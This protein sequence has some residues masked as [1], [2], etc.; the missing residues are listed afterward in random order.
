LKFP[1]PYR[2]THNIGKSAVIRASVHQSCAEM[3]APAARSPQKDDPDQQTSPGCDGA[4]VV[5]TAE[6][7]A[8]PVNF[9]LD[10][11]LAPQRRQRRFWSIHQSR[12]RK[13]PRHDGH[14]GEFA[15]QADHG[16][17]V[18]LALVPEWSV[19]DPQ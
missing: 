10:S 7:A 2:F 3:A 15:P 6:T 8:N 1:I 9:A 5:G 16:A 4:F 12:K 11:G 13:R 17:G 14:G 19:K 18:P